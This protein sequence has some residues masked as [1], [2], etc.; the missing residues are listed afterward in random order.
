MAGHIL[1]SILEPI[2]RVVTRGGCG[3]LVEAD[4]PGLVFLG[5]W[6]TVSSSLP[7]LTHSHV[8]F[9]FCFPSG[10]DLVFK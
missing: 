8:L 1:E 10:E 4:R 6:L 3:V 7:S 9:S 2:S 5:G